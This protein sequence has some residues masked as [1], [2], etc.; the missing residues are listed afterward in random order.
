[1]P[2]DSLAARGLNV[3]LPA[4]GDNTTYFCALDE[5]IVQPFLSMG[6]NSA[7]LEPASR[8][9]E[10]PSGATVA[11]LGSGACRRLRNGRPRSARSNGCTPRFGQL[12]VQ[13]DFLTGGRPWRRRSGSAT[14]PLGRSRP[15]GHR[16]GGDLPSLRHVVARVGQRAFWPGHRISRTSERRRRRASICD[17]ETA[18]TLRVCTKTIPQ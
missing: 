11:L 15:P 3:A 10:T 17:T 1:M 12:I 5:R 18:R 4:Y 7:G 14:G 8:R 16:R 6:L 9:P 2:N 13:R